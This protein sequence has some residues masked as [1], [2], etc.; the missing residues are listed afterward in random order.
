M[1]ARR[2]S[3]VKKLFLPILLFTFILFA[4]SAE[5]PAEETNGPEENASEETGVEANHPE[6]LFTYEFD[7]DDRY[8]FTGINASIDGDTIL[9]K[10]KEEI[11]RDS[12]RYEYIIV[13][14][15]EAK[16][17]KELSEASEEDLDG[18]R[19]SRT[20][21]SPDGRYLTY[22]CARAENWFVVYDTEEQQVVHHQQELEDRS[23][24][25][26]GITNNM[27]I[28]LKSHDGD[29]VAVYHLETE[30]MTEFSI[31]E[32]SGIEDDHYTDLLVADDGKKI[33]ISN[34]LRIS[35]L[36]TESGTLE[37]VMNVDPYVERFKDETDGMSLGTLKVS[38]N[39]KYLFFL[40]GGSKNKETV[41]QS[42]N[43]VNVE[44]G[45][46]RSFTDHEY[47]N[48]RSIDNEGNILLGDNDQMYLYNIDSD[49]TYHIP[50]VQ[51][52]TY[53]KY[54]TLTGDGKHLL[55]A[56]RIRDSDEQPAYELF[57]LAIEEL[58][59]YEVVDFQATLE[60]TEK[61]LG[62]V[63]I[64]EHT[65]SSRDEIALT[66]VTEDVRKLI[67]EKW[68]K[69]AT[70]R[71]PSEFPEEVTSISE[72]IHHESFKQTIRLDPDELTKRRDLV[73][74]VNSYPDRDRKDFCIHDDLELEETLDGVD[75]YFYL[76]SN[77]D[78]ELAFVEGDLC[79]ELK[80]KGF[81]KDE[82]FDVIGSIE[83]QGKQLD[84]LPIAEVK[85]PIELPQRD[86]EVRRFHISK[87]GSNYT[88]H[89]NYYG[90]ENEL[91]ITHIATTDEPKEFED[92]ENIEVEVNDASEAYFNESTLYLYVY[93]GNYY[94]TLRAEAKN[95]V[96]DALGGEENIKEALIETANSLD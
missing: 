66:P 4:C 84:G 40:I 48:F 24:D 3:F 26:A 14:E 83:T 88:F 49:T 33:F 72:S 5:D 47:Q 30:D 1:S 89:V 56:D 13:G 12:Q 94:Y 10:T 68:E 34:M 55:Y 15:E 46:K 80:G 22:S 42:I 65:N 91:E 79:Y 92:K 20:F 90:D 37:K 77:E 7:E 81:T 93:D 6:V 38:P 63:A 43:F 25:I 31:P 36:D 32:L 95:E 8:D 69:S 23:L 11:K 71:Y 39:G 62:E 50:N 17:V 59:T 51:I 60:D 44:T 9:F 87:Q 82:M 21:I 61:L 16:N 58:D 74:T 70:I 67:E 73:Y 28:I 45:E 54:I 96:R 27:E 19:C 18:R 29:R 76:F 64:T 35:V 85:F 2:R 75:Y 57:H 52:R 53:T 78:A 41:Y 86:A